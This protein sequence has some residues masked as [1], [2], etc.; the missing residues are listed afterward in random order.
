V[1]LGLAALVGTGLVLLRDTEERVE[2]PSPGSL[3]QLWE[4]P[5]RLAR[6]ELQLAAAAV[7]GTDVSAARQLLVELEGR[8]GIE[9]TP[10]GV[11]LAARRV[12]ERW[13]GDR[14]LVLRWLEG[15]GLE[16]PTALRLAAHAW[17]RVLA[18]RSDADCVAALLGEAAAL[19][20]HH[21]TLAAH[22]RLIAARASLLRATARLAA[23]VSPL[24]E[25]LPA[26]GPCRRLLDEWQQARGDLPAIAPLQWER[27]ASLGTGVEQEL[28]ARLGSSG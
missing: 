17:E 8:R 22:Q 16:E 23:V 3:A 11:A 13:H 7:R 25:L 27:L 6:A 4:E 12:A 21:A 19:R 5:E 9:E 20:T 24:A 14:L 2:V 10:A 18:A 15:A 26:D 28:R 1:Q